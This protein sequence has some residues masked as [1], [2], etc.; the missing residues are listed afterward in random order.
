[1]REHS[2]RFHGVRPEPAYGDFRVLTVGGRSCDSLRIVSRDY[3]SM[4][5]RLTASGERIVLCWGNCLIPAGGETILHCQD[6]IRP[7]WSFDTMVSQNEKPGQP[8]S[9]SDSGNIGMD[10]RLSSQR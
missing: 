1:M 6:L 2:I 5:E 4:Q 8:R 3:F 10:G 7:T 9:P